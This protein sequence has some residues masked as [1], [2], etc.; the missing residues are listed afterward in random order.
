[1]SYQ[2]DHCR[3][4]NQRSKQCHAIRNDA[5]VT[6]STAHRTIG[7]GKLR[8]QQEHYDIVIQKKKKFH[9]DTSLDIQKG[10]N[11]VLCMR[12]ML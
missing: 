9:T 10:W 4:I 2:T 12:S 8:Q 7:L 11:F 5:R 1:M 3:Y 6:G